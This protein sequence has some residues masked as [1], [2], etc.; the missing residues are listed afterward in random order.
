TGQMS[1]EELEAYAQNL[2]EPVVNAE[3]EA[4]QQQY[5]T[6]KL[7]REQEIEDLV[8]ALDR[9]IQEQNDAYGRSTADIE[10]RA[11]A[12]G[13]GRS[14]YTLQT[15]ANQGDALARAISELTEESARKQGQIQRQI[16]QSAEQNAQTQGRIETDYA[17]NLAAK[18]QEL[19]EKQRDA[20]NSN[21]LTAVSAALGQKTTGTSTQTGVQTGSQD[22]VSAGTQ[23]GTQTSAQ[24][25]DSV[26]HGTTSGTQSGTQETVS[27][28]TTS[29]MQQTTGSETTDTH[30]SSS[31]ES[32]SSSVTTSS[33]GGGG[34]SS[35][36]GGTIV[37]AVSKA[38][39]AVKDAVSNLK[40]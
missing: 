9:S 15:L 20:N 7:S 3:K 33:G 32:S 39:S 25:T 34:K 1:E 22:T 2:L 35:S 13:M 40:K 8:R 11:L 23:T 14:S 16:T 31:S 5:E 30:G 21:Y 4:S 6:A 27:T 37:S 18:M 38:A 10:T 12:R 28:G 19:R 24:Q 29:G 17:R 26:T 36:A